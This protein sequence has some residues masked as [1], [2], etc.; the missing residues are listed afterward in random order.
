MREAVRGGAR[1]W[2]GGGRWLAAWV[3]VAILALVL[4]MPKRDAVSNCIYRVPLGLGLTY[5]HNC[6][7]G[8]IA[9][10]ARNIERYLTEASPSRSR[11]VHIFSVA[12]IAHV[13]APVLVPLA[14][15]L[16]PLQA[17]AGDLLPFYL[18]GVVFNVGVLAL[19]FQVLGRLVG[20][21]GDDRTRAALMGLVASYDLTLA[22][23]WIPHQ[24]PMNVLAPLGG[25]LAFVTGMRAPYLSVR[26]L[27]LLGLGIALACLTYGYCLVWPVAF[28]LGA[29]FGWLQSPVYG[30]LEVVRRLLPFA[31][32]V[33]APLLLWL[34]AFAL[35]GREVA[36]EAQSVGQFTWPGEALRSGT[37]MTE[38]VQ[39][40]WDLAGHVVGFLGPWGCLMPV[41]AAGL[42]I[43]WRSARPGLR[44]LSDPSIAGCIVTA[45]LM[46]GFNYLQGYHQARLLLFPLLLAQV[47][48][49]RLLVLAG[50]PAAILPLATAITL[51]Q[52]GRGFMWPPASME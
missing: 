15:V 12:A 34:G 38:A 17:R 22:W 36:Y 19:S 52:V 26:A 27:L 32:A 4:A 2:P 3:A 14:A 49:L 11:P 30:A 31:V 10:D 6:D 28:V 25:G 42:A 8:H 29:G 44:V 23:F 33:C 50:V 24:I 16:K 7:S 46:L 39:R 5:A 43:W 18:A 13:L 48:M 9:R 35:A 37:L 41:G 51:L 45:M 47:V 20:G 40:A 21:P 1:S